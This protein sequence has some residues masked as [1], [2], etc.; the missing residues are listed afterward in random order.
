LLTRIDTT[1]PC[2][3]RPPRGGLVPSRVPDGSSLSTRTV[4]C[5]KPAS[6]RADWQART[7]RQPGTGRVLPFCTTSSAGGNSPLPRASRIGAIASR[8][9]V[10]PLPPPKPPTSSFRLGL[11]TMTLAV[12]SGV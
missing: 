10:A 5:W 12:I 9:M 7:E 4:V 1:W 2:T 3:A 8:Q 11:S 6:D